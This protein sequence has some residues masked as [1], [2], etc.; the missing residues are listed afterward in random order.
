[1]RI[2]ESLPT[3]GVHYYEV[4]VSISMLSI[5]TKNRE[6]N[7]IY[8][9]K[10]NCL[11]VYCRWLGKSVTFRG[12]VCKFWYPTEKNRFHCMQDT[13]LFLTLSNKVHKRL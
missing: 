11:F 13:V 1:M 3:Y 8:I 5:F 2:A 12:N 10:R 4:K 7:T 6:N 9:N